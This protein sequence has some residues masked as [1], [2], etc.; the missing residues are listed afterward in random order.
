MASYRSN[1]ATAGLLTGAGHPQGLVGA[2]HAAVGGRRQATA[3]RRGDPSVA[4]L[5]DGMH[6]NQP[7]GL[8][9]ADL[10]GAPVH[11]QHAPAGRVGTL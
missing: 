2:R 11:L 10:V 6:G 8:E 5:Q 7:A 9:D 4:P 1:G 3:A